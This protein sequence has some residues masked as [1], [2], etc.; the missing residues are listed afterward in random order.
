VLAEHMA[1]HTVAAHEKGLSWLLAC[2][3]HRSLSGS[4]P[5]GNATAALLPACCSVQ[6]NL[7]GLLHVICLCQLCQVWLVTHAQLYV[8]QLLLVP[9]LPA[10][11]R[12][13]FVRSMLSRITGSSAAGA[14]VLTKAADSRGRRSN[15]DQRIS[16]G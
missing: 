1:Q 15:A 3:G 14:K 6:S 13:V 5:I 4:W 10:H 7:Q 16:T 12:S 11:P 2:F 9:L 8:L